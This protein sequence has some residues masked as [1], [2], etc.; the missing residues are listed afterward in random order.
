M[1]RQSERLR[2]GSRI[3]YLQH[4]R[5]LAIDVDR[6]PNL[7]QGNS[8]RKSPL[9]EAS[10][11]VRRA[12]AALRLVLMCSRKRL[13]EAAV[14]MDQ[15]CAV[16]CTAA[17]CSAQSRG[18][19]RYRRC[20]VRCNQAHRSGSDLGGAGAAVGRGLVLAGSGAC[21]LLGFGLRV[22]VPHGSGLRDLLRDGADSPEDLGTVSWSVPAT[23][24]S[25]RPPS[26]ISGQRQMPVRAESPS[27]AETRTAVHALE[28]VIRGRLVCAHH[29][30]PKEKL[31]CRTPPPHIRTGREHPRAATVATQQTEGLAN[32][33]PQ[34]A[35]AQLAAVSFLRLGG[36]I[37]RESRAV[38]CVAPVA[39]ASRSLATAV[40]RTRLST[41][42]LRRHSRK[43]SRQTC[44]RRHRA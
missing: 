3:T 44:D 17:Q 36:R 16:Y 1:R 23:I 24:R 29:V 41:H 9:A 39:G 6:H 35:Q 42:Q 27:T 28:P 30:L 21:S 31:R 26:A 40:T 5:G 14:A 13:P 34:N 38:A 18:V 25:R 15:R 10:H 20:C 7:R 8:K 12:R 43:P 37:V 32:G 33:V 4:T 22:L 19:S 11:T 2:C